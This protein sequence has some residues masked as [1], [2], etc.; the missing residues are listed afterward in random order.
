[1]LNYKPNINE[2]DNNGNTA[3][4]FAIENE[5]TEVIKILINAKIDIKIKNNF[6]SDM[7]IIA[8]LYGQPE[9]VKLFLKHYEYQKSLDSKG[10]SALIIATILTNIAD[11]NEE[12]SPILTAAPS[13]AQIHNMIY[14][15]KQ[16][17]MNKYLKFF[18]R[19]KLEG[20]PKLKDKQE[21][22][23]IKDLLNNNE[24]TFIQNNQ[25]DKQI[26]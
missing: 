13:L 2:Q 5:N 14:P 12:K 11:E 15:K 25:A 3:I 18:S 22:K 9:T 21:Y 26:V 8:T 23:R 4:M 16:S 24:F 7:V 19:N 1:M 6:G 10:R 17:R 20:V